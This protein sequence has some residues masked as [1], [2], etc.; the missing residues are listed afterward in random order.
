MSGP[1]QVRRLIIAVLAATALGYAMTDTALG[2]LV[3]MTIA[4]GGLIG[5]LLIAM[6]PVRRTTFT[7]DH[8]SGDITAF[9]DVMNISHVRVAGVGGLGLVVVA[10]LVSLQYQLLTAVMV[11]GV[12]GGA[13]G[14]GAVILHRQRM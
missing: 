1:T 13:V 5:A 10:L 3:P 4:G 8:F 12:V 6:R 2:W 9:P 11:A 14:A 7:P